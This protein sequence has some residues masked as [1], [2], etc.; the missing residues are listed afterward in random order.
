[1]LLVTSRNNGSV[2]GCDA[3]EARVAIT[4]SMNFGERRFSQTRRATVWRVRRIVVHFLSSPDQVHKREEYTEGGGG[5][6][7]SFVRKFWRWIGWKQA[8]PWACWT[9]V[10]S[11]TTRILSWS[12]PRS[13]NT[14]VILRISLV[15][16]R[17][18]LVSYFFLLVIMFVVDLLK[19]LFLFLLIIQ[20]NFDLPASCYV[21][22]IC[23][24][25]RLSMFIR[26][27]FLCLHGGNN[28]ERGICSHKWNTGVYVGTGSRNN[29]DW[30]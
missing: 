1:M 8:T 25:F 7:S 9:C 11:S 12:S 13:I 24:H 21:I 4:A 17:W 29:H 27:F 15:C 14:W 20:V 18:K 3:Q 2:R 22:K 23:S 19:S 26:S 16:L 5:K 6:F 30:I 10:L 28:F